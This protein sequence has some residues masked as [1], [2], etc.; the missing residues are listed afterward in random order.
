M[1][2]LMGRVAITRGHPDDV[3][4]EITYGSSFYDF[5]IEEEMIQ[6]A[7]NEKT[8]L[9]ENHRQLADEQALLLYRIK[10]MGL[11]YTDRGPNYSLR[12]KKSPCSMKFEVSM[13]GLMNSRRR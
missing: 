4:S 13:Q 11:E 10:K 1:M 9:K 6:K 7:A 3:S 12:Q 5:E 2:W 8:Y